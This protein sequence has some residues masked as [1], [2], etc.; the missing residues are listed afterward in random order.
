MAAISL[1]GC[2]GS[3]DEPSEN[4]AVDSPSSAAASASAPA[5]S[6]PAPS[7]TANGVTLPVGIRIRNQQLLDEVA[8]QIPQGK[9]GFARIV[10]DLNALGMTIY[11]KGEPPPAVRKLEGTTDSGVDVEI[12]AAKVS[13]SDLDAARKRILAAAKAGQIPEPDSIAVNNDFDGLDVGFL[14]ARYDANTTAAIRAKY[15]AIA[16][17]AIVFVVAAQHALD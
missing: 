17:L 1:A 8:A 14:K 10:T 3:G 12:A 16:K 13:K 4:V 9:D 11:W 5:A 15:R 7:A 2:G 6:S